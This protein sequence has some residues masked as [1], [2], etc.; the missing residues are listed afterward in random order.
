M[1]TNEETKIEPEYTYHG[2]GFPVV[3]S[4]APMR[5]FRGEWMLDI[6]PITIDER[7]AFALAAQPSRLTG[8]KVVFVRKWSRMS[9]HDFAKMLTVSHV[10]VIKWEKTGNKP[11]N[12]DFNTEKVLRIHIFLQLGYSPKKTL[13]IIAGLNA[14]A[15]ASKLELNGADMKAA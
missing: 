12:M 5:K 6:D 15:K 7:V 8:K 14:K 10:A 1:N 9:L 4:N 11:T 3:I 2:C 13:K